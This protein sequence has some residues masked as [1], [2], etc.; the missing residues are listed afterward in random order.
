[1]SKIFEQLKNTIAY[2]IHSATYDP[3]AEAYAA[4][5]AAATKDEK[6]NLTDAEIAKGVAEQ[7]A[8]AAAAKKEAEEAAAEKKAQEDAE[9][10][11]F[12]VKRLFK[13]AL[14]ITG[15][16]TQMFIIIALGIFGASLATNLNV[17]RAW[18]YR[19]LYLIYGFCFFF[20][21]IPYV[22]LWRWLYKKKRPHFYSLFPIIGMHLDNPT[23]AALF[24]WLSFKP[25][26]EMELLNGCTEK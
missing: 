12:S 16:V 18:P 17:Y 24:S 25:D 13:R 15:S 9:R 8:A 19:V 6:A 21:V 3:D 26:S 1:M 5:Q 23:A 14:D 4:K 2:Q 7:K 10:N 11:T 20:I 22:L